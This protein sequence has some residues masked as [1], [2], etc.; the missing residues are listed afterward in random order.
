MQRAL[1]SI[2]RRVNPRSTPAILVG[3]AAVV[4]WAACVAPVL[5]AEPLSLHLRSRS[6]VAPSSGRFHAVTERV[7]WDPRKSAIVVCD[8]WDAHTCPAASR[9]VAAMAPRMNDL[10]KAARARGVFIVHAPSDTMKFYETHPG[11]KLAQAAPAAEPVVPL[12]RWCRLDPDREGQLPI[13]DSDGG[14]DCETSWKKGDP[15]PWTRQIATLEITDGDAITDSA[16]A[17]NLL[18]QRGIKHLL[19]MGVHTNMCVLG[20]PFAIRQMVRQGLDVALVR[21][22]TDTLY[23]P[24]RAPFVNHHT[25]TDL[26]VE[27]IER[28]WCPTLVS[29]D[30][31]DGKE[32]RFPD[33]TR[34][35]VVIVQGEDEYMTAE[36]LPRFAREHLGKDYRV[37][38]VWLDEKSQASFPGI[39]AVQNADILLVSARRRPLPADQLAL[40]KAHVAAGKPVLGIRT[41]SHAFHLRDKPAPEGLADWP[42]IDATVFGGSYSNHHSRDLATTVR[43]LPEAREHPILKGIPAA[44]FPA[45]G[46]LYQTAPLAAGTVELLRG[47][48]QGIE[49]EEPAAW[50]FVRAD[51]GRSFYTSLGDPNDFKRPEFTTL[52][53]NAMGW[54]SQAATARSGAR[55]NT[56]GPAR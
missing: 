17:Y 27:H 53:T 26:V 6:E 11:R 35:H 41:A 20:R 29:G 25:G 23:N 31:L 42:D 21:D 48:T 19:V 39:D 52:L 36:T 34:P 13:D 49:K 56:A 32:Y 38:F 14:C 44:A 47:K 16:E 55:A 2:V 43:P 12:E 1:P 3:L 15:Y 54:L 5:G 18:R 46:G 22:L 10:L 37:S 33:D 40:L 4:A 28:H 51:G 7:E 24:S 50:T 45:E 30:F 9:R 8:M